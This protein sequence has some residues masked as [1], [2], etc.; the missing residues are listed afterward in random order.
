LIVPKRQQPPSRAR[1][2]AQHP[3][4]GVHCDRETYEKALALRQRH[5]LS[6]GQQFK[7]AL[8]LVEKDLEAVRARGYAE[9][10]EA[11]RRAGWTHALTVYR[12]TYPCSMCQVPISI[13]V[14]SEEAKVATA[15]V[16]AEGWAHDECLKRAQ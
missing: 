5:G 3:T 14:G 12:L 10:L 16:A 7:Q 1:W 11:G 13:E 8:D 2:A 15:A 4:I 6:F 9:G